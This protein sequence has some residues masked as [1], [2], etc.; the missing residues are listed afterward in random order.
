MNQAEQAVKW[1]DAA[2]MDG[3]P[4]YPLFESDLNLQNLWGQPCFTEFMATLKSQWIDF[5]SML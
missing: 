2:A 5:Q 4:C 3:F 1:L